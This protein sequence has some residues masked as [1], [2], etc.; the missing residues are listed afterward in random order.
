MSY[1]RYSFTTTT[2]FFIFLK[3]LNLS[4]QSQIA[5]HTMYILIKIVRLLTFLNR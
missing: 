3:N 2:V 4:S 1:H 5:L